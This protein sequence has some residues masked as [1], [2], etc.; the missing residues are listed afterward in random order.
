MGEAA[1]AVIAQG[2]EEEPAPNTSGGTY[3]VSIPPF[4]NDLPAM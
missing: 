2:F 4:F 3:K 1:T